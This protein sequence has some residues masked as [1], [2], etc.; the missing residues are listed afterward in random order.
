MALS[1]K[2]VFLERKNWSSSRPEN[3]YSRIPGFSA[4]RYEKINI[5]SPV[6]LAIFAVPPAQ[7]GKFLRIE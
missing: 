6:Q 7:R 1:A 3:G 5:I 4:A 2:K